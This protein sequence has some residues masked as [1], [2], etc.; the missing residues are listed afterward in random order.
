MK[1]IGEFMTKLEKPQAFWEC[2]YKMATRGHFIFPIDA[3]N[4]RVLEIWDL[5][6]NSE[7]EFDWCICEKKLWPVQALACGGGVGDAETAETAA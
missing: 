4:H 5:N 2:V 3:K 7:Y 6:F 1:L